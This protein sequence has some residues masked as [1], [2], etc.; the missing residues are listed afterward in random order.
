M[1]SSIKSDISS[2]NVNKINT[3]KREKNS[4]KSNKK[5][6]FTLNCSKEQTFTDLNEFL[7][8]FQLNFRKEFY[9]TVL[10][11]LLAFCIVVFNVIVIVLIN[12]N[13]FTITVFD[14]ILI[15]HAVVDG[16]TGAF[17]FYKQQI[18]YIL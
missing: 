16:L 14:E 5:M 8:C 11:F 15:G 6:N 10:A 12:R 4:K 2:R 1:P 9:F 7:E 18:I 3:S 13:S 17:I